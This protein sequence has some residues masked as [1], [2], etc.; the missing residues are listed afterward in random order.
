MCGPEWVENRG[1]IT[2]PQPDRLQLCR[3]HS[4]IPMTTQALRPAQF[5]LGGI[6][7][8]FLSSPAADYVTGQTLFVDGGFSVA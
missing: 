1:Y 8:L 4:R 5:D 2:G 7:Q 3:F 6:V